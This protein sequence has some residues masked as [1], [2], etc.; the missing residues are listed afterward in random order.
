MYAR[1]SAK[2][3]SVRVCESDSVGRAAVRILHPEPAEDAGELTRLLGRA[4]GLIADDLATRFRAAGADDVRIERGSADGRSFGERLRGIAAELPAG[5]G[6][7]VLGAGSI[8][9]GTD[10]DFRSL[11]ATAALG[12]R[13]ALTNNRYSSDVLAA[14]DANLLTRIP[15]LRGDNSL[16]RV[17]AEAGIPVDELAGRE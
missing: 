3:T 7:V 10:A 17:L 1:T 5:S 13:R 8:V 9:L 16:P 12:E 2:S 4:R 14:G 15:N 6:L 11:V